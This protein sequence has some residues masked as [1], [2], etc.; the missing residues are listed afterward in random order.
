M[1]ASVTVIDEGTLAVQGDLNFQSVTTLW[2]S[3]VK[4]SAG[5]TQL[6]IDL[7]NVKRSDSSGVALLVEWLRLAQENQQEVRFVNTPA[8][9]R[10]I[11]RVVELEQIL[12]LD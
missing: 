8:Q 11:I 9:M 1:T 5:H 3:A 12:P 2:E 10:A 6:N 7:T 4:L